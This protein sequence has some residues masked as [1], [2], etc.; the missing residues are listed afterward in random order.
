[1]MKLI[2]PIAVEECR[3]AMIAEKD[4]DDMSLIFDMFSD[5][6]RLKIMNALFTHELCVGDLAALLEMS[7]SA[8]SHQ[9]SSLKKTRLVATRKIGKHVYYSMA[10]EHIKN[11]YKMAYEHIRE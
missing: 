11:I 5:S 1:M 4:Y 3:K 2:D 9:L 8:I 7:T 10:D 6:T